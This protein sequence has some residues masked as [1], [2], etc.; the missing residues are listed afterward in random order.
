MGD[1][2]DELDLAPIEARCEAATG[3]PWR[4]FIRGNTIEVTCAEKCPVVGW[5]GFDDSDRALRK[6]KANARFIAHSRVDIPALLAEVERLRKMLAEN[7][8][9][10]QEHGAGSAFRGGGGKQIDI[11][12]P[13]SGGS[14][15][16]GNYDKLVSERDALRAKL[17]VC[18]QERY[19]AVKTA[20]RIVVENDNRKRQSAAIVAANEKLADGLERIGAIIGLNETGSVFSYEE[21]LSAIQDKIV[22]IVQGRDEAQ[23]RTEIALQIM[24]GA[25][26]GLRN[27]VN[28]LICYMYRALQILR[29]TD[30]IWPPRPPRTKGPRSKPNE[31]RAR[32]K[33]EAKAIVWWSE[34]AGLCRYELTLDGIRA[35]GHAY[36]M[37][38]DTF[39]VG[40][41]LN[42]ARLRAEQAL[43]HA[44]GE[45]A[46]LAECEYL[47]SKRFTTLWSWRRV[48][49]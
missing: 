48:G 32:I 39:S 22:Q 2:T 11:S 24:N 45:C 47:T 33:R 44:L 49:A 10:Q 21:P 9:L 43:E 8:M 46:R 31:L 41:G 23:R 26:A 16:V 25:P 13:P 35:T 30:N 40:L 37:P 19:E 42:L 14:A 5:D 4:A 15:M 34:C 18:E 17:A 29:G 20:A 38:T 12:N 3:G 36:C 6:H 7:A 28:K 1:F 27:D